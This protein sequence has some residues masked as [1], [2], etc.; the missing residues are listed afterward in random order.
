MAEE[1]FERRSDVVASKSV[2]DTTIA[3]RTKLNLSTRIDETVKIGRAL[4]S[5]DRRQDAPSLSGC[6]QVPTAI[7]SQDAASSPPKE[8][9]Y[10]SRIQHAPTSAASTG[11]RLANRAVFEIDTTLSQ[12]WSGNSI[13]GPQCAFEMSMFMCPAVHKLTR[14]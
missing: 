4:T 2:S 12:E 13:L 8:E 3:S 6:A 14:N 7:A 9:D 10:A 5:T 11:A 1:S